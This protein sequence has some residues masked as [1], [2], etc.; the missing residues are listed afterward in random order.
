MTHRSEIFTVKTLKRKYCINVICPLICE[1]VNFDFLVAPAEFNL[2]LCGLSRAIRIG[3][4][5]YSTQLAF[6]GIFERRGGI[7]GG[8]WTD[9]SHPHP[10]RGSGEVTTPGGESGIGAF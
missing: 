8:I 4:V 10:T 2:A 1:G 5:V 7:A 9:V 3:P 6:W